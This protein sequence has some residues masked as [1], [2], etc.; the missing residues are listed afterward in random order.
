MPG[1]KLVT[2]LGDRKWSDAKEAKALLET[3]GVDPDTA[4]KLIGVV[5]AEKRLGKSAK[6]VAKFITR[7]AGKKLVPNSDKRKAV[8]SADVFDTPETPDQ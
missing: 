1:H 8:A 4:P 3:M 5:E 6:L 7:A 2:T